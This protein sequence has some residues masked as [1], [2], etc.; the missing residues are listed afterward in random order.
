MHGEENVPEKASDCK[1][2]VFK[3]REISFLSCHACRTV[4][5]YTPPMPEVYTT[6]DLKERL[7]EC[8]LPLKTIAANAEVPYDSVL[9]WVSGTQ[10]KLPVDVAERLWF[11]LTGERFTR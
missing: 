5:I 7:E 1:S 11:T 3:R 2:K 6:D 8:P 4:P 9:R 10:Q